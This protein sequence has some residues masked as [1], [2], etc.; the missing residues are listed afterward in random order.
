VLAFL[1]VAATLAGSVE[2][3]GGWETHG[4]AYPEVASVVVRA[5][6][7]VYAAA[8]DPESGQSALFQSSDRAASWEFV[9]AAPS[10]ERIVRLAVEDVSSGRMGA[11]TREGIRDRVYR[12]DDGGAS[13]FLIA[14]LDAAE[15]DLDL[16]FG[17]TGDGSLYF[18][19]GGRALVAYPDR[20]FDYLTPKLAF[21]RWG[22][23]YRPE[24]YSL[25]SSTTGLLFWT[26][27]VLGYLGGWG[28]VLRSGPPDDPNA[29]D[30]LSAPCLEMTPVRADP[31]DS[32]TFYGACGTVVVSHDHARNWRK[33]QSGP[34]EPIA[35]L[36]DRRRA[37]VL[38]ALDGTGE[39]FFSGDFGE[40]WSA[41]PGL[42]SPGTD[43]AVGVTGEVLYAATSSGVFRRTIRNT[44]ELE[45]RD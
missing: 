21:G 23:V 35:L 17:A 42:P 14:G 45:P 34:S 19:A 2:V 26:T 20:T 37:G 41:M 39:P 30:D 38:F 18:R 32:Q 12:S 11:V 5:D 24:V 3:A 33:I 1:L 31:F 8:S 43:L 36:L 27:Q 6:G 15:P 7:I 29:A 25:W 40:G 10:D 44:R 22:F 28:D 4:P 9:I 16:F 13:W